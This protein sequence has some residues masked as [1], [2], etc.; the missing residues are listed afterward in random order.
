M[1]NLLVSSQTTC[2]ICGFLLHVEA[3]G[4]G[5]RW[6]DFIRECK[7]LFLRNIYEEHEL[8]KEKIYDIKD[9]YKVFNWLINLIPDFKMALDSDLETIEFEEF[10]ENDLNQLCEAT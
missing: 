10:L 7:Y 5:K 8:K 2:C 9:F 3:K 6:Y 1:E 4:E